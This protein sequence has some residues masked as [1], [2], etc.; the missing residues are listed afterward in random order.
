MARGSALPTAAKSLKSATCFV[1]I[2]TL[3]VVGA[4]VLFVWR[5]DR[6]ARTEPGPDCPVPGGHRRHR[7]IPVVAHGPQ[8]SSWA[9]QIPLAAPVCRDRLRRRPGVFLDH[10]R[11]GSGQRAALAGKRDSRDRRCHTGARVPFRYPTGCQRLAE[12]PAEPDPGRDRPIYGHVPRVPGLPRSILHRLET[13][14][15]QA[16][17]LRL[18]NR[19]RLYLGRRRQD[20]RQLLFL[21]AADRARGT[22]DDHAIPG[23]RRHFDAL[24]QQLRLPWADAGGCRDRGP[25]QCRRRFGGR[26]GQQL[27]LHAMRCA[28]YGYG[29]PL[30]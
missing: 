14:G 10:T 18:P 5:R 23:S 13:H 3:V 27:Q 17:Q 29:Y 28:P 22:R 6:G 11:G 1:R 25:G 20:L 19:R 24:V 7:R 8:A 30:R 2:W 12:P 21:Q 15:R 26:R 9:A 16:A 4:T